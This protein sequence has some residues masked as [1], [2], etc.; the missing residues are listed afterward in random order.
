MERLW[1]QVMSGER[2]GGVRRGEEG[3]PASGRRFPGDGIPVMLYDKDPSPSFWPGL[4]YP[5]DSP[6]QDWGILS[7]LNP[8]PARTGYATGG[9][10]L[11]V[12]RR[13]FLISICLLSIFAAELQKP[14][15]FIE[16]WNLVDAA[17]A[18]G[19]RLTE[20]PYVV[21]GPCWNALAPAELD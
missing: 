17:L 1:F 2:G 13:T 11:A 8:P 3:T 6:S 9:T 20:T 10:P 7:P 16:I 4:G 14:L 19:Y 18:W 12:F 21:T 15:Q 5:L